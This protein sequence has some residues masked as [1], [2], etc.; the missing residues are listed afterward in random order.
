MTAS[1]V[2]RPPTGRLASLVFCTA[3]FW[4][5]PSASAQRATLRP[6]TPFTGQVGNGCQTRVLCA[7]IERLGLYA[8]LRLEGTATDSERG[9]ELAFGGTLAVGLDLIRRV[10]LEASFPVGVS[11]RGTESTL[12][13]SGPLRLGGRLRLGGAAPTMFAERPQPRLS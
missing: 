3:I 10:A 5:L 4:L 7:A 8:G 11:Y 12:L 6:L 2:G 9:R 1:K 13:V